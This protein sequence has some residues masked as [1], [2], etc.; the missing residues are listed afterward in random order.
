MK[1]FVMVSILALMG[2]T[3][4]A[5]KTYI[6]GGSGADANFVSNGK[7]AAAFSASIGLGAEKF[8]GDFDGRL[9]ASF[10]VFGGSFGMG[11]NADVLYPFGKSDV[12][13]YIGAGLGFGIGN[14]STS[15]ML[16]G[17]LGADFE[18]TKTASFF[19]ELEPNVVFVGGGNSV[20]LSGRFGLKVFF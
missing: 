16:R 11:L 14:N 10:G 9:E 7:G 12:K 4:A 5:G 20:N 6:L 8:L 17:V 18:F 3:L 13:P 19:A 2:S 1:K 15:V